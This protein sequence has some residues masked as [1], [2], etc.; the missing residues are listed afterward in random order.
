V[1]STDDHHLGQGVG[2]VQN[3]LQEYRGC[4]HLTQTLALRVLIDYPQGGVS[5]ALLVLTVVPAP[6]VGHRMVGLHRESILPLFF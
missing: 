6:E 4:I 3:I 1:Q 5:L 2:Q